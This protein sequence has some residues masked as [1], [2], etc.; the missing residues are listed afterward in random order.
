MWGVGSVERPEGIYV[1]GEEA[2][3]MRPEAGG[4]GVV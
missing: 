3:D 2:F 4:D 1:V